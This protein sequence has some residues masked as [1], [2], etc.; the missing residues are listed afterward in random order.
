MPAVTVSKLTSRG[1]ITI[2]RKIRERLGIHEGE[3]VTLHAVTQGVVVLSKAPL[4]RPQIAE[5]LLNSL[6]L[7]IG[8]EAEKL[9]L[10]QEEDLEPVIEAIRERSFRE[11]YGRA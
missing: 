10:R 3:R 6:V 9:G 4:S 5:Y 1:R 7:G 8:P 2:P 11:R